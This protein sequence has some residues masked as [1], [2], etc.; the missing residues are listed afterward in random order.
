VSATLF[1]PKQVVDINLA[2]GKSLPETD[3]GGSETPSEYRGEIN[4]V[5]F[6]DAA[7]AKG[8]LILLHLP[9]IFL[10]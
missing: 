3:T 6:V 10:Y 7:P 8:R 2:L 4:L 1:S 9:L 5:N